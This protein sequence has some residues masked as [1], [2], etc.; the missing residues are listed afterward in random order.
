MAHAVDEE[1]LAQALAPAERKMLGAF[2]TPAEVVSQVFDWVAPFLPVRGPTRV[3]DPACGAGAFLTQAAARF[4]EAALEGWDVAEASLAQARARLGPSAKLR[5]ADFLHQAASAPD[6]DPGFTLVIGNPPFNGTSAQL[7]DGARWRQ[8]VRR[9]RVEVPKGTSL[10]ED[11]WFFLLRAAEELTARPGALAFITSATV[12]DAFQYGGARRALLERLELKRVEPL[13]A[14][15][16]RGTKVETCVTVWTSARTGTPPTYAETSFSPS[17]PGWTLRPAPDD[18]EALDQAWRSAG[19]PL[20]TLVPVSF[21]GLKLRFDELLSDE[22]PNRLLRRMVEL[23]ALKPSG[24]D[25]FMERWA[26]PHAAR[27]KLEL[28]REAARG[29]TISP[30]LVRPLLRFKGPKGFGSPAWCYLERE[31]I[32]RGDHRLRGAYDP[33]A[34][35]PKLV[36]NVHELPLVSAYVEIPG[37]VTAWRHTRFAP[38]RVPRRVLAEGLEAASRLSPTECADLVPNLS[39]RG[40]R[41]A[42][43]QPLRAIA[44][45]L[46]SSDVQHRWAP[47]FGMQRVVAVPLTP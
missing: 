41:W 39:E 21:P 22:D 26:L 46:Q 15:T 7:T 2:F 10:R 42:R 11:Y 14:G 9:L 47:A 3:V 45:F 25:G 18:A 17:A 16:F 23:A 31:L 38:A 40:L 13:P 29:L 8:L 34:E 27:A 5:H 4:P 35:V 6:S 36:F 12:V 44:D 19:E 24:V 1:A 43:E 32:P 37:C 28:A 30:R 33:H 20:T